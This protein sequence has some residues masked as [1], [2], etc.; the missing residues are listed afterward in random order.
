M[1]HVIRPRP[2][3]S[4]LKFP[5]TKILKVNKQGLKKQ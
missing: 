5:I 4:E 2:E 1:L 3:L